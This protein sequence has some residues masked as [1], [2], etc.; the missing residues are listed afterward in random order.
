MRGCRCVL[1]CGHPWGTTS[2][3][4]NTVGDLAGRVLREHGSMMSASLAHSAARGAYFTLSAQAAR[5]VLQLL[6]VV[7]LARIL[8]PHDYG[9]LAIVVVLIGLGEIFRDFGLTSAAIQAPE[10]SRGQRDN[11]FWVNTLI[12]VGLSGVMFCVS[13]PLAALMDEPDLLGMTQWLSLTFILNGLATQYRASLMRDLRLRAIAISD[14]AASAI[15]LAVAV[16][17]ALAGFGFWALVIQQ[18]TNGLVLLVGA[19][20]VGRWMPRLYSRRHPIRPLMS[21]GVNL[22]AANLVG[23]ASRQIDAVLISLRFGTASLGLYNR[24]FQLVMTPLSQGRS[25]LQSVAL[26]VLSRV[27]DDPPRFNTYVLAAQLALGYLFGIPLAMVAGLAE[28]VVAIMLGPNWA[29]SSPLL[30]MFAIAGIMTTLAFV[31]YWVYLARGLGNQLFRYTIVTSLIKIACIVTGSFFGLDGVAIAFAVNAAIEWPLSI[32]WLSRI[33]AMP[34]NGLYQGA[35][36]VLIMAGTAGVAAWLTSAAT[37]P[38]GIWWQVG[39]GLIAGLAAS[40]LWLLAPV[41][42]RDAAMLSGFVKLM[43]RRAPQ[44]S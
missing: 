16:A 15:A 40:S 14:V 8:S 34:R 26:P 27:Q 17:A 32:Y 24:S 10:L 18:L 25:P 41:Y 11:L 19:V 12:G 3:E 6:S 20:F 23:Y 1:S 43:V 13:W 33:T 29:A 35:A 31:G 2:Q 44:D 5:I 4:G 36:R 39:L 9:L 38:M 37:A 28:P 22:M 7:V 30:R 42:R 21:F